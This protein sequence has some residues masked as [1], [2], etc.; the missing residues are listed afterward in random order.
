MHA[1]NASAL[2]VGVLFTIP[3]I[4]TWFVIYTAVLTALR[5]HDRD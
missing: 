1:S 3:L 2:W 4:L 5:R